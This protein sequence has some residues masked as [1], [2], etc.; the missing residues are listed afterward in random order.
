MG[1]G[2]NHRRCPFCRA[3]FKAQSALD[4][5]VRARHWSQTDRPAYGLSHQIG[6]ADD[7]SFSHNHGSYRDREGPP[8]PL[9]HSPSLSHHPSLP[10]PLHPSPNPFH[11]SP[12]PGAIPT[13]RKYISG[14]TDLTFDLNE[15]DM[16]EEEEEEG[17]SVKIFPS[18]DQ[19]HVGNHSNLLSLGY[20]YGMASFNVQDCDQNSSP[21][22]SESVDRHGPRQQQQQRQ[23]TQMTPQQVIKLRAC[24]REHPTP[25]PLQC[26]GLG[27]QLGLPRRVVQVWFQNGRA[28]EKR[29]R[30]L[31]VDPTTG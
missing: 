1:L 17:L 30:S 19:A 6:S 7:F 5:H 25:S 15:P 18:S 20:K 24:Y 4:A 8:L 16:E 27:R 11:P 12:S 9:Q 22:L 10:S 28:K 3:L 23:R 13:E 14:K 26:E 29:A 2:D 31:R 21:S